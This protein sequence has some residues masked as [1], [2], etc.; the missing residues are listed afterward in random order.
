MRQGLDIADLEARTKIRAKYLRA[1]ENEEF[2][3]LPG[4]TFVRTFLR[5]YAEMLGL[6][7]HRLVDE[8]RT[9][10]EPQDELE[11]TPLA[12]PA[13]PGRDPV[14][15]RIPGPPGPGAVVLLALGAVIVLLLV[16]GLTSGDDSGGRKSAATETTRTQRTSTEPAR[17]KPAP[18]TV[19]LQVKTTVPTYACVDRGA[20]TP[21]LFQGTL[22]GARSFT[23]K[24]LRVNLGKTSVALRVNGKAVP[25]EPGPNPAGFEFTVKGRKELPLGQRP[26]A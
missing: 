2:S 25:L 7:P 21:V 1:L 26:C 4:T 18:K 16:L 12:P 14:R 20:G 9:Q 10:H 15:R 24:R 22:D 13:A 23:G 8:Y 5:T 11:P 3:T 19:R 6:D 17:P